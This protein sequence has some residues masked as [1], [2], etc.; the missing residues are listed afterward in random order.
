MTNNT[1]GDTPT[2]VGES[3]INPKT[4]RPAGKLQG[5]LLLICSC[6]PVLGA[7]LLAPILPILSKEFASSPGSD[8]LVP[9]ILTIPALMIAI[10]APFAGAIVDRVGRKGV[11][12]WAM[13]AYAVLGTMPLWLDTLN[14]IVLALTAAVG[15]LTLAIAIIGI[16][17]LITMLVMRVVLVRV[18]Q[19]ELVV[20]TS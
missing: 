7:V 16:L 10:L 13:L 20:A 19:P 9:L 6:L 12:V 15:G 18:P 8:A 1:L 14:M 2:S 4:G 3:A 11:L 17:S 5:T